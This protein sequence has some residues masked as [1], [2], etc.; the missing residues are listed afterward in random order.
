MKKTWLIFIILVF[1]LGWFS[2]GVYSSFLS[3][4]GQ[5]PF[6][7]FSNEK[8]SP[9]KWVNDENI[10]IFN[11]RIIIN[12]DDATLAGFLDTNS[13]DPLLDAG[14][15][16]IEIKPENEDQLKIGDVVAYRAKW[17][18]GVIIHRIVN[19]GYDENGKYFTLKGDNN[20]REDPEKVRFNQISYVLIG[21]IY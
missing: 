12:V 11:D 5:A 17:T 7:V 15:T 4:D 19:I 13:M 18:D 3:F 6:K 21:V 8:P 9:Q 16:G 10:L 20:A 2:S 14:T 1:L